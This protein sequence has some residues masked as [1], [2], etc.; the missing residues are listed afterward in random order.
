MFLAV[1][2]WVWARALVGAMLGALGTRPAAAL[3]VTPKVDLYTNNYDP[4]P[5]DAVA[6]YTLPT[7]TGYAAAAVT[8]GGPVNTGPHTQSMEGTVTFTMTATTAGTAV[9]YGCIL[10]DGAAAFYG[11]YK[12]PAPVN[13][14]VAGDFLS[15]TVVLP[16][17]EGL[18]ING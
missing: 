10:T 17:V 16:Q 11:A 9:C 12:F 5:T 4:L 2:A 18:V 8:L 3:L 15:L 13:F 14:N 1:A 6:T 7:F